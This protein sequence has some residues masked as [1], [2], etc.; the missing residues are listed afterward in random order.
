MRATSAF[1]VSGNADGEGEY[2]LWVR[3][4]RVRA[5]LALTHMTSAFSVPE[6]RTSPA[7][8][9][10]CARNRKATSAFSA[11][12]TQTSMHGFQGKQRR[13]RF[14]KS[15]TQTYVFSASAFLSEK[16]KNADVT[17]GDV[18]VFLRFRKK[19][20]TPP[21]AFSCTKTQTS[22]SVW[23]DLLFEDPSRRR[24]RFFLRAQESS[25][26]GPYPKFL[27]SR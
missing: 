22:F 12:E 21:S 14:R 7:W 20:Q 4:L 16:C 11:P 23:R 9:R 24:L 26:G 6:T 17:A 5:L 2:T 3:R 25:T 13:L 1:P 15:E 27:V 19:T 10:R 8:K 18:C